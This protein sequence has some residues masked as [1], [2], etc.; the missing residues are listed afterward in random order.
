VALLKLALRNLV[1]NRRRTALTLGA[2]VFG[3]AAVLGVRGFLKGFQGTILEN[4]VGGYQGQVQVHRAGYLQNVLGAPLTLDMADTPGLRA[5]MLAV[6]GVA[7][8]SPRIEFGAQLSTPDLKP[9]PEDGSELPPADR[10]TSTFLVVTGLDFALDRAVTPRKGAWVAASSGELPPRSDG[11]G[12]VLNEDFARPLKLSVR[13][14]GLPPAP[15]ELLPALLS[16]DRDG[17]L[18]G[19]TVELT[20]TFASVT[21][22]D[23][24]VGWVGLATAQRLLRMEGRVT[25]Y[26]LAV[27]PGHEPAEVKARLQAVLGD[28]YEVITWDERV[29]FVKDLVFVQGALFDLFSTLF[30]GVV[31]LGLV[32]A[33][34]MGVLE[35]VREIGTLL[36]LGMRSGRVARLFVLEGVVLGFIGAAAG[37]VLGLGLVAVM[38]R[39]GVQMTAPGAKVPVVL[40]PWVEPAFVARVVGQAV[41]GAGL[42]A[43]WPA[44]RASRLRP[45]EALAHA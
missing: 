42:A 39:V 33:M 45:V 8:L 31:L 9:A 23:R 43:L 37:A 5:K 32:N 13:A 2:L 38:S 15:P 36:A 16:A 40:H 29:P 26:A 24:R 35:R 18:N 21:A 4:Q 20:G 30:L 12:L 14:P 1:R 44:R 10:G 25:E 28:G 34:L 17:S 19:E 7:A 11:T 22:N 27:S 41:V 6:P 3:V